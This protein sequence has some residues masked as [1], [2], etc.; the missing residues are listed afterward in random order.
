MAFTLERNG[1]PEQTY[2]T[3]SYSQIG[4]NEAERGLLCTCV[5]TTKSVS[6]EREFRAMADS[7]AH[8]IYTH[9]PD[10]TVEWVNSRWYEYT[11]LPKPIAT[12]AEGWRTSCRP[13]I[14]R[15]FWTRS[16]ARS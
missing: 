12:T 5:E 9:A 13:R 8:I 10:G 3:F 6:R 4:E 1:Y 11:R 2:F 7:I 14:W 16:T 15:S